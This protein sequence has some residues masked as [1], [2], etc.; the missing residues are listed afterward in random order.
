MAK[1]KISLL[2]DMLDSSRR[3]IE[4]TTNKTER[5][6]LDDI[7]LQDAV[8]RRLAI[9]GEAAY[10]LISKIAPSLLSEEPDIPWRKIANLRHFLV[11]HYNDVHMERVWKTAL[12]DLPPLIIQLSNITDKP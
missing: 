6:F 5:D 8:C 11:H 12:N 3:V 10:E 9:I 2:H 7:I 1:T 4:Y